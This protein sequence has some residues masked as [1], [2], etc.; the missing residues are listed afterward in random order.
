M[1]SSG[2]CR[3]KTMLAGLEVVD[4]GQTTHRATGGRKGLA[5]YE[6]GI[7]RPY[8][9]VTLSAEAEKL[10]VAPDPTVVAEPNVP[11]YSSVPTVAAS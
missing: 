3:S 7:S 10:A 1:P 8:A 5:G 9:S 4:R 6:P 11:Q 2:R